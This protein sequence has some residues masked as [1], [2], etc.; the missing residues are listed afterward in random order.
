MSHSLG[1]TVLKLIYSCTTSVH[2][3]LLQEDLLLEFEETV[4]KMVQAGF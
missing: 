3:A 4:N 2:T 1:G